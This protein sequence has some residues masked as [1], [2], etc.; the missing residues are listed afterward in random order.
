MEGNDQLQLS[1]SDPSRLQLMEYDFH[2]LKG[3]LKKA[4]FVIK[5]A[6]EEKKN[7]LMKIENFAGW[8]RGFE[9]R[10]QKPDEHTAFYF[11][12]SR[13]C[14]KQLVGVVSIANLWFSWPSKRNK[15]YI[16]FSLAVLI[17]QWINCVICTQCF[18]DWP[19]SALMYCVHHSRYEKLP[20]IQLKVRRKILYIL[21]SALGSQVL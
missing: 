11:I 2:E 4:I 13:K 19:I 10:K 15:R 6:R 20:V 17:G 18:N 3:L 21:N 16:R 7:Y 8:N 5:R 12:S 14:S 1:S 9:E